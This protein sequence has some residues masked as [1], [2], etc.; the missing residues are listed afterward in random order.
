MEGQLRDDAAAVVVCSVNGLCA[1]SS[2]RSMT[3]KRKIAENWVIVDIT[4]QQQT[5]KWVPPIVDW[6]QSPGSSADCSH[7]RC[8]PVTTTWPDNWMKSGR[9]CFFY[10]CS[11]FQIFPPLKATFQPN[12]SPASPP[13]QQNVVISRIHLCGRRKRRKPACWAINDSP[14]NKWWSSKSMRITRQIPTN[15]RAADKNI[16]PATN[17]DTVRQLSTWMNERGRL[18]NHFRSTIGSIP[19]RMTDGRWGSATIA[20]RA[21][22]NKISRVT[23]LQ[24]ANIGH[25]ERAAKHGGRLM[26]STWLTAH[27]LPTRPLFVFASVS[28]LAIWNASLADCT[29]VSRLKATFTE[30]KKI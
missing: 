4:Q 15:V 20:F 24:T 23:T 17:F 27:S 9:T 19:G 2:N 29:A 18:V 6:H 16:P 13:K 1:W 7:R 22:C 5:R 12:A 28:M 21:D 14:M 26:T 3:G 10:F 30:F 11:I 8:Q 25:F